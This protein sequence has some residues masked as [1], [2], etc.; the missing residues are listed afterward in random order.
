MYSICSPKRKCIP[1]IPSLLAKKLGSHA[2]QTPLRRSLALEVHLHGRLNSLL[3]HV[4]LASAPL[5][6]ALRGLV[7][8]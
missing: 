3:H 2:G 6:L 1:S 8:K 7:V 5:D 4:L